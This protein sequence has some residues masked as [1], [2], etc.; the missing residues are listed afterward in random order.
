M[1]TEVLFKKATLPISLLFV[2]P[3][4]CTVK[5]CQTAALQCNAHTDGKEQPQENPSAQ[6]SVVSAS[7]QILELADKPLLAVCPGLMV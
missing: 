6:I 3:F 4:I 5:Q 2:V 7:S 1:Q